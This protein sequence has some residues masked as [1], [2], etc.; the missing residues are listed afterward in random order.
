MI[1]GVNLDLME[2]VHSVHEN[3]LIYLEN[4]TVL[5]SIVEVIPTAYFFRALR[6]SIVF[7]YVSDH[8]LV[9]N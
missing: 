1:F 3:T 8:S 6:N 7:Q 4:T 5:T 9:E 2:R